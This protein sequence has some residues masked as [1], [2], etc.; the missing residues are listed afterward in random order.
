MAHAMTPP[1]EREALTE[2]LL[3]LTIAYKKALLLRR[4]VSFS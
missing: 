4:A 1:S 3:T 2:V